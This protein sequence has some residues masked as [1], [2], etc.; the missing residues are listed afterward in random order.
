MKTIEEVRAEILRRRNQINEDFNKQ[1]WSRYGTDGG[2]MC[3]SLLRFIDEIKIG[4]V[5]E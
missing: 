1:G 5:E 2:A 3:N 4:Y